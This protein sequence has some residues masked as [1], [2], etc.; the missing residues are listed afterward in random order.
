MYAVFQFGEHWFSVVRVRY[1]MY[2]IGTA[3]VRRVE[4]VD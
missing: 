4:G 3:F 1:S 2:L